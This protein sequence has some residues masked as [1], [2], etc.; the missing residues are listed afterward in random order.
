M[1]Y[2]SKRLNFF[3]SKWN[4]YDLSKLYMRNATLQAEFP[5]LQIPIVHALIKASSDI[6][7]YF[8]SL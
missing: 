6:E 7:S 8:D 5:M 2:F 4:V 3:K 1:D